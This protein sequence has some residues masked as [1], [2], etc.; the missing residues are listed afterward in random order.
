MNEDINCFS[1]TLQSTLKYFNLPS[2]TVQESKRTTAIILIRGHVHIRVATHNVE[3]ML[4]LLQPTLVTLDHGSLVI[5]TTTNAQNGSSDVY[6]PFC[7]LRNRTD[8]ATNLR[9]SQRRSES[10]Y[11]ISIFVVKVANSLQGSEKL[12]DI[13]CNYT[14]AVLQQRLATKKPP[15][16]SQRQFDVNIATRMWP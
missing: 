14:L 6:K 11:N 10:Y 7:E 13:H 16:R 4:S 12:A 15:T 9:P 3:S 5:A 2:Y 1:V 8:F